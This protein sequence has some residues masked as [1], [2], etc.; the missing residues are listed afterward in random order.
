MHVLLNGSSYFKDGRKSVKDN[1]RSGRPIT[2][3][4]KDNIE[5]VH[6]LFKKDHYITYDQIKA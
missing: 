1:L 5:L 6:K 4:N 3:L 2:G